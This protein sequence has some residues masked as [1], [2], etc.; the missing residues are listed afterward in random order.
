LYNYNQDQN[1]ILYNNKDILVGD[2][3]VFIREW[4]QNGIL[5]IQDLI[6]TGQ[7][8]SYQDFLNNYPCKQVISAIPKRLLNEAKNGTQI[9]RELYF[10]NTFDFQLDESLQ[11]NLKLELVISTNYLT[12]KRIRIKAPKNGTTTFQQR[13]TCGKNVSPPSNPFVKSPS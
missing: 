7:L 12:P 10:N 13:K 11:I 1:I 9:I 4:Y 3:P 2:K 5:S 6:T 8:M